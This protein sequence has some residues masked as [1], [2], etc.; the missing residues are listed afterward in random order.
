MMTADRV[1]TTAISLFGV[2]VMIIHMIVINWPVVLRLSKRLGHLINWLGKSIDNP[3]WLGGP[4]GRAG[5]I[6]NYCNSLSG[7]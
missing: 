3:L 7:K 4:L 2:M 6:R 1:S 5:F